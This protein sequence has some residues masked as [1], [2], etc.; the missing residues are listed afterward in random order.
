M[1]LVLDYV[2]GSASVLCIVVISLDRY[3]LVS[4]GL[5]YISAQKISRAIFIMAT[6]WLIAFFNYA[7]AIV[8]WELFSPPPLPAN[9]THAAERNVCQAGFHDNLVY[10]TVTACVEFFLP[11]I[12]ICSLN[13]AVYLNIRQRS[14]GLIRTKMP[15]LLRGRKLS[16]L[17][18]LASKYR[19]EHAELNALPPPVVVVTEPET[20]IDEEVSR[21]LASELI[22][23]QTVAAQEADERAPLAVPRTKGDSSS[24]RSSKTN[25]KKDKNLSKDKKAARSLFILVFTFVVCWVSVAC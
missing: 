7:P 15:P 22:E 17:A 18:G 10:L 9:A 12:S 25:C 20:G 8:F 19:A 2:V 5:T 11:F 3:W 23:Q 24:L 4:R 13:L 16:T 6:C 21:Q 1:W 14:K